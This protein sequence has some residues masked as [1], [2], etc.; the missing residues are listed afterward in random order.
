MCQSMILQI[1]SAKYQ[2]NSRDPWE[3]ETARQ[4]MDNE[5]QK[6]EVTL[7]FIVLGHLLDKFRREHRTEL[8]MQPTNSRQLHINRCRGRQ[9]SCSSAHRDL[10]SKCEKKN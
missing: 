10:V 1:H 4:I 7:D 2:I 6:R 3:M 8:I 5:T 9:S